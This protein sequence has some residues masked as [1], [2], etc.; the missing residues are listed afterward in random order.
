M[1]FDLR[2]SLSKNRAIFCAI[3]T[4]VVAFSIASLTDRL[5]AGFDDKE[6]KAYVQIDKNSFGSVELS[7]KIED[8]VGTESGHTIIGFKRAFVTDSSLYMWAKDSSQKRSRPQNIR[9]SMKDKNGNEISSYILELCQPLSWSL[10]VADPALGGFN[11]TISIAAQ[12][13]RSL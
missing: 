4:L 7:Q 6:L 1:K 8:L 11:E 2:K 12:N 10:E 13:I 9:I 5:T 3:G